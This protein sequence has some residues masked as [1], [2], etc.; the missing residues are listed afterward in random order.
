MS[1][2]SRKRV[3][4][5]LDRTGTKNIDMITLYQIVNDIKEWEEDEEGES[6]HDYGL[7]I[8]ILL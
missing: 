6:S 4:D 1:D 7:L 8:Y 3:S 5:E 2:G